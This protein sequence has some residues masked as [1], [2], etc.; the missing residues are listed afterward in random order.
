[1]NIALNVGRVE[2]G[3]GDRL[4]GPLTGSSSADPTLTLVH[5]AA[6]LPSCG[7]SYLL[8]IENAGRVEEDR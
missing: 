8:R 5:L 2:A 6:R 3:G 1:M 7:T 4:Y